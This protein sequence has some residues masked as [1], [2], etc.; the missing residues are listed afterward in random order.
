MLALLMVWICGCRWAILS[1]QNFKSSEVLQKMKCLRSW[2]RDVWGLRFCKTQRRTVGTDVSLLLSYVFSGASHAVHCHGCAGLTAPWF[3]FGRNLGLGLGIFRCLLLR[4][5]PARLRYNSLVSSA[6]EAV[7]QPLRRWHWPILL[8]L[9]I[10][11][12]R[13]PLARAGGD[14]WWYMVIRVPYRELVVRIV[15]G[16]S[17]Y[18]PLVIKLSFCRFL[19]PTDCARTYAMPAWGSDCDMTDDMTDECIG[20]EKRP[21]PAPTS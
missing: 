5:Q 17:P 19:E 21:G 4:L 15:K 14:T 6:K 12:S 16:C 11:C 18:D 8:H 1:F 2:H 3:W 7:R 9:L 13:F 10:V 20:H